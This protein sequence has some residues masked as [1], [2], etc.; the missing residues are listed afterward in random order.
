MGTGLVSFY[1]ANRRGHFVGTDLRSVR[2]LPVHAAW[3]A[4]GSRAFVWRSVRR[5]AASPNRL[6]LPPTGRQE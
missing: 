1:S 2:P 6:G 4:T 3:R 5:K